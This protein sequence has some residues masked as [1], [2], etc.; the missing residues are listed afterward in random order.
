MSQSLRQS[1]SEVLDSA[2]LRAPDFEEQDVLLTRGAEKHDTCHLS[3][4]DPLF[5]FL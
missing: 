2:A 3:V 5:R 1:M 4:V